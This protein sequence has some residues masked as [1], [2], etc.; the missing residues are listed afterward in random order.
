MNNGSS[1]IHPLRQGK[2]ILLLP[3]L[4]TLLCS[5]SWPRTAKQ[6]P[7]LDRRQGTR[8]KH[9]QGNVCKCARNWS[10]QKKSHT[11]IKKSTWLTDDQ[12]ICDWG[13]EQSKDLRLP[14]AFITGMHCPPWCLIWQPCDYQIKSLLEKYRQRSLSS[15]N[16]KR[17]ASDGLWGLQQTLPAFL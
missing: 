17:V 8:W 6:R 1:W 14:S 13:G 15:T 7:S 3:S 12:N 5:M 9:T 10:S 4:E 11:C 2:C 16:P